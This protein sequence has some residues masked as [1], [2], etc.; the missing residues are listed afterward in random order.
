MRLILTDHMGVIQ[1]LESFA[2]IE[3]NAHSVISVIGVLEQLADC[4]HY[5]R[6]TVKLS[7]VQGT[8]HPPAHPTTNLKVR[9]RDWQGKSFDQL[10]ELCHHRSIDPYIA[11][12]WQDES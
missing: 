8:P 6:L 3:K 2:F 4:L 11:S 9:W 1:A 7:L 10:L 12:T 5:D